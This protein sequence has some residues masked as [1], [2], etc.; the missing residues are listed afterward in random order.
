VPDLQPQ[1]PTSSD[2]A[3][4][5]DLFDWDSRHD[6]HNPAMSKSCAPTSISNIFL[7]HFECGPVR[8]AHVAQQCVWWRTNVTR[9]ANNSR[10]REQF[11]TS[12]VPPAWH[13]TPEVESLASR[14]LAMM[15]TADPR[16]DSAMS[17]HLADS[18]VHRRQLD[19]TPPMWSPSVRS[20]K[21]PVRQLA[22][23]TL[24][25]GVCVC[26]RWPEQR[27]NWRRVACCPGPFLVSRRFLATCQSRLYACIVIETRVV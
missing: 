9:R 24:A 15:L 16:L 1:P 20:G 14:T 22:V 4:S 26:R 12:Q 8:A 23:S 25:R 10:S 6:A 3:R 19:K 18:H 11:T 13:F 21:T 27:P 7:Q 17:S 5:P 2:V